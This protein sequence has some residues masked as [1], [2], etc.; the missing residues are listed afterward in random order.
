[1]YSL[2]FT[3]GFFYNTELEIFGHNRE[4]NPGLLA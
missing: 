4:S 1:M 2:S 3:G